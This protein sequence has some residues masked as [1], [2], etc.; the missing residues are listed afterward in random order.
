M[1]SI[2]P[3]LVNI[4]GIIICLGCSAM[5]HL[6]NT[7]SP[8]FSYVLT[9]L[10]YGGIAFLIFGSAIPITYYGFACEGEFM[11]RYIW[12]GVLSVVNF[13]SFIATLLKVCDRKTM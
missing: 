10:D 12:I 4:F 13:L 9:K 3:M 5:F 8:T 2:V 1:G 11:Q 6:C 7:I